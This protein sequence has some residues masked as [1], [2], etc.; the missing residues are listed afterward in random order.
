M[1]DARRDSGDASERYLGEVRDVVLRSLG[2]RAATVYLFVASGTQHRASD[3]DIAIDSATPL[4][5]SLL[6]S[7]REA[8]GESCVP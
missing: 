1:S 3:I 2:E 8:L 5:R 7:L 4:P 6:A